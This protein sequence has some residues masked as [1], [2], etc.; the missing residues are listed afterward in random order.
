[1]KNL[2]KKILT[3]NFVKKEQGLIKKL[4]IINKFLKVWKN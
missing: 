3:K 4:T 2:K 1:M